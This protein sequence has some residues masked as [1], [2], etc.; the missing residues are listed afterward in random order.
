MKLVKLKCPNCNAEVE[1]N[2]DLENAV[3]NYCGS[4]FLVEDENVTKEERII[5]AVS[6]KQEKDREYY[7]SEAYEKKLKIE[8]DAENDKS[9]IGK[10]GRLIDKN[11]E[12]RNSP[13]YKENEKDAIKT[14]IKVLAILGLVIAII[15]IISIIIHNTATNGEEICYLNDK[16]YDL[17]FSK[18]NEIKCPSCSEE[19]LNELNERYNNQEDIWDTKKNIN[20]YFENNGGYCGYKSSDE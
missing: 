20:T 7:A 2:K 4:N 14:A 18:N 12:Y 5:K 10:I 1:V 16:K 19:M 17:R 13:E 3:C 8:T 9:V 6:K 11:R 15:A